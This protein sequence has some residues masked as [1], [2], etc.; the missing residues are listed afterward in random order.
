M[1]PLVILSPTHQQRDD[2]TLVRD[3]YDNPFFDCLRGNEL[4]DVAVLSYSHGLVDGDAIFERHDVAT[5]DVSNPAVQPIIN[6]IKNKALSFIRDIPIE[7]D[8]YVFL[9]QPHKALWDALMASPAFAEQVKKCNNIYVCESSQSEISLNRYLRVLKRIT[10]PTLSKPVFMRSGICNPPELAYVDAG[11]HVG[12]SL[13]YCNPSKPS[14][15]LDGLLNATHSKRLFIDNGLISLANKGKSFDLESVFEQYETIIESLTES[16][17]AN[18]TIVIPDSPFCEIEAL[19]IVE[20]FK[21]RILALCERCDVVLPIHRSNAMG[22]LALKLMKPLNYDSRI[23]LGV[24]CLKNKNLNLALDIEQ[25]E[26]LFEVTNPIT[27]QPMFKKVHF[28]GLTDATYRH[29]LTQRLN[30]ANIYDLDVQLDGCRT[31]ALFSAGAKGQQLAHQIAREHEAE[32][33][34]KAKVCR[35]HNYYQESINP[36]TSPL[37]TESLY[38]LLNEDDIFKF[39]EVFD[40]CLE[41]HPLLITGITPESHTP[42]EALEVSWNLV[43]PNIDRI[44]FESLK[45]QNWRQHFDGI[46]VTVMKGSD[47]RYQSI[48]EMYKHENQA[49]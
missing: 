27:Q 35:E 19:E 21:N 31:T 2:L 17:A 38:D 39:F 10:T 12:T 41:N 42:S 11:C 22:N 5:F 29:K 34:M 43:T 37:V 25:I 8:V 4:V 14:K 33:A 20:R 45:R 9:D 16:Q 6:F 3:L 13:Y 1:K 18:V 28:F 30:L 32:Q 47:A 49:A 7:R 15:L 40:Q 46:E 48:Y 23:R 24:P 36:N 44:L 26:Q